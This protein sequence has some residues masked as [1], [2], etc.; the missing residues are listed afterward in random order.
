[1]P[2]KWVSRREL[3]QLKKKFRPLTGCGKGVIVKL[4]AA[5]DRAYKELGK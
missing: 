3:E 2:E 5:L 1:M 4:I